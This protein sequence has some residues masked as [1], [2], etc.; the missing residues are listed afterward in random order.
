MAPKKA[1][2]FANFP[3]V[4]LRKSAYLKKFG[5]VLLLIKLEIV[6]AHLHGQ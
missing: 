5:R 1:G 6:L 4:G 3:L 2:I